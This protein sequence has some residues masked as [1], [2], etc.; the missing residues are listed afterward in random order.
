MKRELISAERLPKTL[1]CKMPQKRAQAWG[2]DLIVASI[3][4]VLGIVLFYIYSLNLTNDTASTLDNLEYNART[5]SDSLLTT[6]SPNNWNETSVSRIGILS[7]QKINQTKLERF[8][9][10]T[11]SDYNRTK[12]IFNTPYDYYIVLAQG[13]FI[14]EN[15]T[16]EGLGLQPSDPENLIKINRATIYNNRPVTIYIQIWN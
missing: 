7:D 4:F 1:L 14:I 5:V 11:Q 12:N 16:V 13:S 15:S 10:L 2:I 8:Y 3:I 9:N 6:G